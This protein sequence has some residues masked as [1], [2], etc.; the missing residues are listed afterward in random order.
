MHWRDTDKGVDITTLSLSRVEVSDN[1]PRS[2]ENVSRISFRTTEGTGR[3]T[4][5]VRVLSHE[6]RTFLR[7][8]DECLDTGGVTPDRDRRPRVWDIEWTGSV[9]DL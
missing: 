3:G 8:G 1:P 4:D 6:R 2:F 9:R 7:E 5:V